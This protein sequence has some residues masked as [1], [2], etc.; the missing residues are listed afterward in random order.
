MNTSRFQT[1]KSKDNTFR[2][3][4]GELQSKVYAATIAVTT[5][6]ARTTVK[7]GVLTG[8]LTVTVGVGS[9]T[10]PPNIGDEVEM[11]FEADA[12]GRTI[13]FST[14]TVP[15]AATL[16]LGISK[17]GYASFMFDGVGWIETG[18]TIGA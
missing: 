1:G 15:S 6:L 18:R 5:T 9:A 8:A 16:V 10:T 2:I 13:T 7:F 14:G 17:K 3:L 12:T 11:L 4:N